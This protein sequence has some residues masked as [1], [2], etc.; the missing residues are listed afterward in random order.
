VI[1]ITYIDQAVPSVA[2][3]LPFAAQLN[4]I[5]DHLATRGLDYHR[6]GEWAAQSEPLPT[7]NMLVQ[8]FYGNTAITSSHYVSRLLAEIG[9][10]IH[11]DFLQAKYNWSD[12][13]WC[14]IAWNSFEIV[15]R[16]TKT[17]Q[18]DIWSKRVHNWLNLGSQRAKFVNDDDDDSNH[19]KQ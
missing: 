9:A 16:R 8:V 12:Q 1:P 7:R 4:M 3:K 10:D 14:H 15:A 5:C 11:H 6:D 2:G 18:A 17:K 13:Q 19:A